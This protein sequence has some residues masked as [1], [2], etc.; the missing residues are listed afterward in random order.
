[1]AGVNGAL[2]GSF[3]GDGGF[4]KS[5]T[6]D[7]VT[8]N[9]NPMANDGRGGITT[10][11]V[12][13][14]SFTYDGTTKTLTVDTDTANATGGELAAVMTTGA[15]TFQP[16]SGFTSERCELCAGRPRRRYSQQHGDVVRRRRGR[17]QCGDAW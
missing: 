7:N 8:Y 15:F 6:V 12:G 3:G 11:G 9:F 10:S 5:I 4:V 17:Y 1:M 13:I 14:P 16:T 2:Q